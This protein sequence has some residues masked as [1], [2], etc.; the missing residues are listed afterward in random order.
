M[1]AIA[2][3]LK[4]MK[5]FSR[6]LS[7]LVTASPL[8]FDLNQQRCLKLNLSSS[9]PLLTGFDPGDTARFSHWIEQQLL[10]GQADY[11][12]GGYGEDRQLYQMSNLFSGDEEARTLHLGIDLWTR[13]GTPVHAALGGR[14]HSTANNDTFGDYGPTIILE[15][16]IEGVQFHTLYGHLSRHSLE[17]MTVGHVIQTGARIGWLGDMHENVG[18]PAH[19]HFQVICNIGDWRGDYPGVC[20]PSD[21]SQWLEKC[22]NP[23]L[24]LRIAALN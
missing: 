20:R 15:H 23:N 9:N 4:S 16:Q 6:L 17:R 18:W 2:D 11:A 14:V 3:I 22:P 12:A 19:L 24:L 21:K 1:S 7:Q 8:G 5:N 13:A 10:I